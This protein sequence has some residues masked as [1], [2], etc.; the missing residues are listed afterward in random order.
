MVSYDPAFAYEI[1]HL[2]LEGIDRM[3]GP[4]RGEDVM[5]YLTVYNE[6]VSQPAEPADLD[7]EGLHKGIYLYEKATGGDHEVSVLA[8]G[9]GMQQ[10]LRAKEILRDE[11]NIGTNIFSVT[12]WV[13]LAREGHGRICV[14]RRIRR[15]RHSPRSSCGRPPARI[16]R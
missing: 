8:S 2:L 1:A 5:Y 15:R 16:L 12:S 4:G 11:Y 9:I 10:A 6:P 13:E 3:Y 14:T 7:V